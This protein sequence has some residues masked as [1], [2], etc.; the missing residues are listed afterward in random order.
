MQKGCT[1]PR[2]SQG[3]GKDRE[4]TLYRVGV[5]AKCDLAYPDFLWMPALLSTHQPTTAYTGD[6]GWPPFSIVRFASFY[7][8]SL[9]TMWYIHSVDGTLCTTV[10]PDY[11]ISQRTRTK[12]VVNII[13]LIS[14][15][16]HR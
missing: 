2:P 4:V 14:H 15:Q 16:A 12:L 3:N 5:Y 9:G 8:R 11:L 10:V 7:D 1:N 13:I 6:K